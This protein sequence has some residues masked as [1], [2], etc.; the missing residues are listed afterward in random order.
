MRFD[1]KTTEGLRNACR[2]AERQLDPESIARN[3]DFL[4]RVSKT[5]EAERDRE[6]FLRLVWIENPLVEIDTGD[7]FDVTDAVAAPDFRRRFL[8]L[9]TAPL[10]EDSADRA[11]RL[12]KA[13]NE[14]RKDIRPHMP[15]VGPTNKRSAPAFKMTRAFAALFPNDFTALVKPEHRKDLLRS[16]GKRQWSPNYPAQAN[17]EIIGR[18]GEALGTVDRSDWNAVARRMMLP[19]VIL[20]EFLPSDPPNSAVG[21]TAEPPQAV[22][23]PPLDQIK[24]YFESIR[25]EGE[26]GF[27]DDIVESLH[28]GLW[29]NERR[30]FAVLTGLSGTGKTLLALKYANALIG[31]SGEASPRVCTIS[32]QPAWYDRTPLLGYVN[33]LGEDRY[34]RTEFLSFLLR[35]DKHPAEAY[36]CVLDEMNLSH[37]EQYL[38]PILSAMEREE[39]TITLHAGRNDE[40][41]GVPPSIRYPR[42][43]VLIGTVNMDE[44][45]MGISDKVLDRAFTLEFWDIDVD[46]WP[47]WDGARIEAP[48]KTSVKQILKLLM[49]ALSPA[50]LHFGWRV[51][52]EVVQ[53]M[54]LRQGQR[55]TLSVDDALDRVI[56]AK[57]LPKLRGD[58]SPRSRDA[59]EK[60][61]AVLK[62]RNLIRCTDKVAE[63]IQNLNETG[64]FRFWR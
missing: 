58:D 35:A 41:E 18:L 36:V 32:V 59:L 62:T 61:E 1:L 46:A 23:P 2:E 20:R 56:Y 63:L 5:P 7:T 44:T 39:G 43:L 11:V 40:Y 54:E 22:L 26:L 31:T 37:P 49:D 10:P 17:R 4:E 42:N 28:L 12:D 50:R 52:A 27:D 60:C 34:T 53:F 21:S 30:H 8:E 57:V 33:P 15:P 45:T 6:E 51:I 55:A 9:T 3:A 24:E 14:M 47:G 19:E 48:A 16:M 25:K 13:Y 64:S 38:A 29:A